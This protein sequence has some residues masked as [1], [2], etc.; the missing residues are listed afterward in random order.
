MSKSGAPTDVA[1]ISAAAPK[2]S[3]APAAPALESVPWP[4]RKD[5]HYSLFVMTI[6]VMFTVL[7]RTVM[8]LL[9]Q[10]IKQDFGIS[11]SQAALL[12]G[13]AFSL[14]YGIVGLCVARIA[15]RGNRRN[16]IA[17]SIA[18]WSACT[19]ACGAAQGFVSLLIAR[20]GIGAGESGYGPASWSIATDN[21]PREKVAFATAT[22]G[23]G[24]MI[25]MGLA[26]FL[27]GATLGLV[28]GWSP[29][30][31]PWGGVIRP[32]QWV[33][34][35]VGAP[36]LLWALVVL[37]T[38]E[39]PRRGITVGQKPPKLPLSE[40]A[41]WLRDDWRT[42]LAV[43]GG[44]GV[45]AMMLTIP[46]TWNATLIH[47]EFGWALSTVGMVIGV[48]TLIVG[49]LGLIC[50]A[51]LSERWT[52]KGIADANLRLIFYGLC[53]TLPFYIVYPLMPH[54]FLVLGMSATCSFLSALV[55]GP[56]IAAAQIITPNPMRA[57]VGSL[58]QFCNNVVAFA[59]S[60]IIVALLT[61]FLFRDEH[62]LKYSMSLNLGVIGFIALIITWQGLKPYA[63]SYARAV[64]E[65]PN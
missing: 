36:G 61:D 19:V 6:V 26:M 28:S 4:P 30:A 29:M 21:W 41:K 11:D 16:I 35:I 25:G 48:I 55:L 23:Q 47:R 31:L 5:A 24:A 10:P 49:P 42:Y 15:D 7:D 9:I 17:W 64:R 22:M 40:I 27:G 18:F 34:V 8:S 38:K 37:T 59:L 39:P 50:G 57:Q 43:V 45:K 3:A 54:P 32:W 65:F 60:P 56:T 33:F 46:L 20:M 58:I 52:K 13:A 53:I 44:M 12:I 1:G 51:K 14:P 62:S 2:G 63:R